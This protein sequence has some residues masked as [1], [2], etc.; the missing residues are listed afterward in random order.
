MYAV[1]K[2]RLNHRDKL[3]R[4]HNMSISIMTLSQEMKSHHSKDYN[5]LS[6]LTK[7]G[8]YVNIVNKEAADSVAE[9]FFSSMDVYPTKKLSHMREFFGGI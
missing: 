6:H 7:E 4:S 3:A 1:N 5:E 8:L 2:F 9:R